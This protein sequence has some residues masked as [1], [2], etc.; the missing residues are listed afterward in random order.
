ML[1]PITHRVTFLRTH[2]KTVALNGLH[3]LSSRKPSLCML[4]YYTANNNTSEEEGKIGF[5][6]ACPALCK[7]SEGVE[8]RPVL[9]VHIPV[10]D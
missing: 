7:A 8:N 1:L 9:S 6:L 4:I 5:Y 10:L 2:P 3:K